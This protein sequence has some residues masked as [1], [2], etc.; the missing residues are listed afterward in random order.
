MTGGERLREGGAREGRER[1]ERGERGLGEKEVR[2][3][4]RERCKGGCNGVRVRGFG[5]ALSWAS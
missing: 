3:A 2:S 1:G 4:E 5:W